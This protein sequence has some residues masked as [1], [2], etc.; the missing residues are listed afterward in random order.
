[1]EQSG[2]E[3][4]R[5]WDRQLVS[6]EVEVNFPAP[7]WGQLIDIS[8]GGCCLWL[9]WPLSPGERCVARVIDGDHEISLAPA[10]VSWV[11]EDGDGYRTGLSFEDI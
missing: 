7:N 11:C 5:A 2:G 4:R 1:M 8:P 3:A 9:G 6:A 10:T